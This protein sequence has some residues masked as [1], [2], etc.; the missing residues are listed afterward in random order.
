VLGKAVP[1]GEAAYNRLPVAIRTI[2]WVMHFREVTMA[3]LV[4]SSKA[5]M[6]QG[7]AAMHLN[8]FS[9]APLLY[10]HLSVL[11]GFEAM[12][13]NG[14]GNG[15]PVAWRMAMAGT[16]WLAVD[17]TC[18]QMM[19]FDLAEVGYLSF[20]ARA[21]YGVADPENVQVIG[22]VPPGDLTRRF[23]RHEI[24]KLQNQWHSPSV[25]EHLQRTLAAGAN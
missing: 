16:D 10:P 21:G 2:P 17:V 18:A 20:C 11:D 8:L 24:E 15:E 19:G 1:F 9:L 5:A 13:G 12:E 3:R 7:L 6:H 4:P 22:N 23:K 25:S 14:P